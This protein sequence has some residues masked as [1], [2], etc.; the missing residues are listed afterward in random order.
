MQVRRMADYCFM[1]H[2]YETALATYR[3]IA[4]DFKNGKDFKY[5]A[6]T[7]EF[8]GLCLLFSNTPSNRKEAEQSMDA[9]YVNYRQGKAKKFAIRAALFQIIMFRMRNDFKKAAETFVKATSVDVCATNVYCNF[10]RKSIF[11]NLPCS[12]NKR[13]FATWPCNNCANLPFI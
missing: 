4:P 10:Y 2:D 7:Q 6:G 9:A 1:L 13:H 5:F 12:L 8:I 11:S 3:L